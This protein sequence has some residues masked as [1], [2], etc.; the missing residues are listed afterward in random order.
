MQ[1][2]GEKQDKDLNTE[3][4]AEAAFAAGESPAEAGTRKLRQED[5]KVRL[6]MFQGPLDLL[7]YLIQRAE[8]DI[9]EVP[10][11]EITDQYLAFLKRID[12][13]DVELAGEFLVMAATLIEVKSR[14]LAPPE[15]PEEEGEA[16]RDAAGTL[17]GLQAAAAGS[18]PGYELIQQLLA[19]QRFRVA[20]EEMENHRRDFQ[21]RYPNRP[22]RRDEP[23]EHVEPPEL[24]IEDV[25]VFDL[26]DAYE[27]IMASID[28]DKLG[29]HLVELDDTPV[30]L[31]QTDLLDRLSR[32]ADHRMTLQ[33][34]FAD[35]G[36]TQR[37]GL[38][39]AA[40]ELV[41]LRRITA[42]QE[43]IDADIELAMIED[44]ENGNGPLVIETDEIGAAD[45]AESTGAGETGA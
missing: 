16:G 30:A 9:T 8:V 12:E 3:V 36:Q 22:G 20:A 45:V 35:S 24:E 14:T 27:R 37:I 1:G 43:D 4:T 34:A 23:V 40:L 42:V 11:A 18:D 41:R 32:A 29:D 31:Y 19:Y 44:D 10:L 25:H 15:K 5:Y 38:F 6:D 7:L 17:A 39:L 2:S 26:S 13:V 33:E 28:L 21:K